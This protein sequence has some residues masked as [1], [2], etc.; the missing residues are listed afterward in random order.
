MTAI[1]D[2]YIYNLKLHQVCHLVEN[3]HVFNLDSLVLL[4]C[5]EMTH[6]DCGLVDKQSLPHKLKR[7]QERN[8]LLTLSTRQI[9]WNLFT[10]TLSH[11][12]LIYKVNCSSSPYLELLKCHACKYDNWSVDKMFFLVFFAQFFC[13]RSRKGHHSRVFFF[14][15]KSL[16]WTQFN[17]LK[18]I[19]S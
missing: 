10:I 19:S 1:I 8:I 2:I 6:H 18:T 12:L 17:F 4:P 9:K 14:F 3:S 16:N 7:Y 11:M 5:F 13:C 15:T